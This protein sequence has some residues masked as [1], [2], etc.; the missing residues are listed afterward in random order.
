MLSLS[1]NYGRKRTPDRNNI[2]PNTIQVAAMQAAE[3]VFGH[4]F[5]GQG[6]PAQDGPEKRT[7][8]RCIWFFDLV[9]GEK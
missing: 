2:T 9:H 5:T 3:L 4:H 6:Y 7:F 1:G 8:G